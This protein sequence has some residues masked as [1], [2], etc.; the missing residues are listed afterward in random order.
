MNHRELEQRL[1]A[2]RLPRP[3]HELDCW[4]AEMLEATD[5]EPP[6]PSRRRVPS[7]VLAG[8][9]VG[10]LLL[11]F[12]VGRFTASGE[13]GRRPSR[14]PVTRT[15]QLD[16]VPSF[17]THNEDIASEAILDPRTLVVSVRTLKGES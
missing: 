14:A 1:A 15:V 7:G 2:I 10:C 6:R 9:A 13:K 11:G 8:T 5:G 4:V 3:S 16:A 12:V 17:F